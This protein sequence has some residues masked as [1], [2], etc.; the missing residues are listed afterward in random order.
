MQ[1]LT[2]DNSFKIREIGYFSF[3]AAIFFLPTAPPI[4]IVLLLIASF[5]TC[6]KRKINFFQ[7]KWN[8][9]FF[10]AGFFMI[11]SCIFNSIFSKHNLLIEYKRDLS[12][13]GLSNWLP[14]FYFFSPFS[15]YLESKR[16]RKLSA[17]ILI[18]GTM[19]VLFSCINQYWFKIYGPFET[20]N[21]L[22][23]WF[24][25]P[26]ETI[27]ITGL[28]SN[29]N[30]LATWL[31]AIWPLCIASIIES[32]KKFIKLFICLLITSLLIYFLFL[33]YSR[34]SFL[35]MLISL[36]FLFGIKKLLLLIFLLILIFTPLYFLNNFFGILD[37]NFI[38]SSLEIQNLIYKFSNVKS[39][40]FLGISRI[41]IW[42]E[43]LKII[44]RYPILGIGVGA[45]TT[46]FLMSSSIEITHPH[47]LFFDVAINY[48]LPAA[49]LIFINFIIIL[50]KS[51]KKIIN[52]QDSNNIYD[53][54]WFTSCLLIFILQISDI[55]Y[56][57]V[58]IST[59]FWILFSGLKAY[60][61]NPKEY[62]KENF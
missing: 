8:Y 55:T 11:I 35:G 52:S 36:P 22:I 46:F 17:K 27:G 21:G 38:F 7:D 39:R 16:L 53:L 44:A 57:D 19:P 20:L 26:M 54:S 6:L 31:L 60:I 40:I 25:R 58:K 50:I 41:Q 49:I 12:W 43:A 3:F 14:F 56:F 48:G 24:Q 1:K 37:L 10:A 9:P 13:L 61:E 18:C 29:P 28:F 34:N 59:L 15:T 47:N 5:S 2:K 51:Y 42:S 4:S 62:I 23:V 33:T 45:F 30:Y 32:S